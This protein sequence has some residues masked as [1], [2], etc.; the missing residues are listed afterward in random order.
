MVTSS[1]ACADGITAT[2]AATATAIIAAPNFFMRFLSKGVLSARERAGC[3]E[4]VLAELAGV[5]AAA[6]TLCQ[7]F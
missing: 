1:A 6:V 7:R 2:V 4:K 5:K 3:E